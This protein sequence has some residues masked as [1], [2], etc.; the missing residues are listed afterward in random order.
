M[1]NI[2]KNKPVKHRASTTLLIVFLLLLISISVSL[3]FFTDHSENHISFSTVSA[4]DYDY[5]LS[6]AINGGKEATITSTS[7]DVLLV[8]NENNNEDTNLYSKVT[9][10]A[11][12]S[13]NTA[14]QNI[15]FVNIVSGQKVPSYIDAEK[16]IITIPF[17][18][19]KI[20]ANSS[21]IHQI[22]VILPENIQSDTL[23]FHITSDVSAVKDSWSET[24]GP[25]NLKLHL[26]IK[27]PVKL[28]V[29]NTSAHRNA[30]L[31]GDDFDSTNLVLTV[32][33]NTGETA[34]ITYNVLEDSYYIDKGKGNVLLTNQNFNLDNIINLE[35]IIFSNPIY[36]WTK[37]GTGS[38]DEETITFSYDQTSDSF[39]VSGNGSQELWLDPDYFLENYINNGEYTII[40]NGS[41]VTGGGAGFNS[42][43]SDVFTFTYYS[44]YQEYFVQ[45]DYYYDDVITA[46]EF[47]AKYV[48]SGDYVIVSYDESPGVEVF[49]TYPHA[50][51]TEANRTVECDIPITVGNPIVQAWDAYDET[52]FH[53]YKDIITDVVF[54]DTY[55]PPNTIT[56]GPWDVSKDRDR[57]V[58]AYLVDTKVYICSNVGTE[59]KVKANENSDYVFTNFT[60]VKTIDASD[61][62][63]TTAKTM[64]SLFEYCPYL[65]TLNTFGWNTSNVT[66]M[67][68]TFMQA[69]N[70]MDLDLTGWDVSNVTDMRYMFWGYGDYIKTLDL[71]GW[72][73]SSVQYA[74]EMF[75]EQ[76]ALT[77]IGDTSSW[78]FK[79]LIEAPYMF[80]SCVD[81]EVLDVSGWDMSNL[82]NAESMFSGCSEL[83]KLD[84]SDWNT[85]KLANAEYM[86][87]YCELL[88]NIDIQNWNCSAMTNNTGMFSDCYSLTQLTIPASMKKLDAFFASHCD[89]LTDITFLHTENSPLTFDTA[90]YRGPF[91]VSDSY[92]LSP[93]KTNV[94]ASNNSIKQIIYNHLWNKEYRSLLFDVTAT[95]T[96]GGSV[97]EN[98]K[99]LKAW[100]SYATDISLTPQPNNGY[101][102]IEWTVTYTNSGGSKQTVSLAK[103][104]LSSFVM[105]YAHITITPVWE[106]TKIPIKLEVSIPPEETYYVPGEDYNPTGVEFTVTYDDNSKAT[107]TYNVSEDTYYI[108]K[109]DGTGNTLLSNTDFAMT[110]VENLKEVY[111]YTPDPDYTKGGSGSDYGGD[112]T[113][114]YDTVNDLYVIAYTSGT[115]YKELPSDFITYYV[116]S[117]SCTVIPNDVPVPSLVGTYP[118]AA[119]TENGVTVECD[120]AITVALPVLKNTYGYLQSTV[121]I[122]DNTDLLSYLDNDLIKEV[123]FTDSIEGL[124]RDTMDYADVSA[125]QNGSVIAWVDGDTLYIGG[126]KGVYANTSIRG[127]FSKTY[128]DG[129]NYYYD[130]ITSID[131]THLKV[132]GNNT[133]GYPVTTD[134]GQVFSG[135]TALTNIIGL[136]HW[137]TDSVTDMSSM[138]QDTGLAKISGVS[139]W[140]TSSVIYMDKLFDGS[141]KLKDVSELKGWDTSSLM[142]TRYMFADC[143]SLKEAPITNWNCSNITD[144]WLYNNEA[145]FQNCTAL[146]SLVIPASMCYLDASFAENCPSLTTITFLHS[147]NDAIS[148]YDGWMAYVFYVGYSLDGS[149]KYW[150]T[151]LETTFNLPNDTDGSVRESLNVYNWAG[152]NRTILSASA[153][154]TLDLN[155]GEILE[156]N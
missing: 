102:F 143:S 52:D 113:F 57:S 153:M 93:L 39:L 141:S 130:D 43:D 146:E 111:S 48:N 32:T 88:D 81:L 107:I 84:V 77:T 129:Y 44:R 137:N 16:G 119:Y 25:V 117:S 86:F 123:T 78:E 103:D 112:F 51:Y 58:M 101:E 11:E 65:E 154:L 151:P 145:M 116:N 10:T 127:L 79:S 7:D 126:K 144:D 124:N 132:V 30:Y 94:T 118:H 6:G 67:S 34:E 134:I 85:T 23:N 29:A 20:P 35:Q 95:K 98:T 22:K 66:N 135:C 63:T 1:M 131:V 109:N 56:D 9:L 108:D 72:N 17:N 59:A 53:Y 46:D 61:F 138:F 114:T 12:W 106:M 120:V 152:D 40:L 70:N 142:S 128:R 83:Q 155:G 147:P 49:G 97:K 42:D 148:M 96:D 87:S 5:T 19:S 55:N 156:Q 38:N 37:G 92:S 33:Y 100:S 149:I 91:R 47:L 110:H 90:G 18:S 71:S 99:G 41:D 60:S 45:R 8:I 64:K 82:K 89:Q 115:T 150:E 76:R 27:F 75:Y 36:D 80:V 69:G 50:S 54:L 133:H 15:S 68:G 4:V 14:I 28:E 13:G 104:Q 62:D 105:P 26:K 2:F 21:I 139:D 121:S 140:D 24:V 73:V 122:L 136:E 74:D 3:A 31:I 125:N